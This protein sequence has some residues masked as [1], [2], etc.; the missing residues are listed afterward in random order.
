M[1]KK[2]RKRSP[3]PK[4]EAAKKK[5]EPAFKLPPP[6]PFGRIAVIAGWTN[7]PFLTA[8]KTTSPRYFLLRAPSFEFAQHVKSGVIGR[9]STPCP[10]YAH[11]GCLPAA[12]FTP[13]ECNR[14]DRDLDAG[15]IAVFNCHLH[16]S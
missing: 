7:N 13:D 4:K 8:D 11:L 16:S 2:A 14:I 12:S 15:D 3:E 1:T 10:H 5:R 6:P 9:T